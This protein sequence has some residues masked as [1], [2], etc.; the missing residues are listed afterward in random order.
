MVTWYPPNSQPPKHSYSRSA[1]LLYPHPH[2][3]R[4]ISQRKLQGQRRRHSR[5]GKPPC[6]LPFVPPKPCEVLPLHLDNN[7]WAASLGDSEQ[8]EEGYVG[9]EASQQIN[10]YQNGPTNYKPRAIVFFQ[11]IILTYKYW[12]PLP[13]P[14]PPR[15]SFGS[16]V[17][18]S[19]YLSRFQA[20]DKAFQNMLQFQRRNMIQQL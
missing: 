4:W 7:S 16:C 5:H 12:H 8:G 15:F 9:F 14:Q 19:A 11:H 10:P 17:N 6:H 2:P 20:Q 3:S 13:N 1:S 18:F